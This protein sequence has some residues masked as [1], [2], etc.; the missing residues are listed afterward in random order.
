MVAH[1]GERAAA[2]ALRD[3]EG[4][5][6]VLRGASAVVLVTDSG[7]RPVRLGPAVLTELSPDPPLVV[8]GLPIGELDVAAIHRADGWSLEVT[9]RGTVGSR[10]GV[11]GA[12]AAP[13]PVVQLRCTTEDVAQTGTHFLLVGRVRGVDVPEPVPDAPAAGRS[14]RL[15]FAAD[16]VAYQRARALVLHRRFVPDS[17]LDPGELGFDIGADDV[18]AV[19]ALTRLSAEG[20]V[21]RDPDRGYVVVPL[22]VRLSDETF[23]ARCAIEVG[24]VD[25]ALEHELDERSLVRLRESLATMAAQLVDGRFVDFDRY[26]DA[27]LAFH[28]QVVMLAGN[29]ALRNAFDQL[30]IKAV[31]TRS[32]GSTRVS[33]HRFIE[34]QADLLAGIELR[35]AV[36]IRRAAVTYRDIA[37]ERV[38]V[39]L[40]QTGGQL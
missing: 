10:I 9:A 21:R 34:T 25:M 14:S 11:P 36:V 27:N 31:M 40:A 4:A 24:A 22:D 18:A 7:E 17:V 38:R 32:F 3:L 16:D 12:P 37:K 20:L 23:D 33:S 30:G 5:M 15:E 13:G 8:V 1:E 19:Y 28:R 26:L 29:N 39:I 6:D 35:D 2:G